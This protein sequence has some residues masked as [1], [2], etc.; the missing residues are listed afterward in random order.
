[1][2]LEE[3]EEQEGLFRKVVAFSLVEVA[4]V[5]LRHGIGRWTGPVGTSGNT[6]NPGGGFGAGCGEMT[7]EVG[8]MNGCTVDSVQRIGMG[9]S[10][11]YYESYASFDF[12]KY[13][14]ATE[15]EINLRNRMKSLWNY[16]RGDYKGPGYGGMSGGIAGGGT[17]SFRGINGD[18]YFYIPDCSQAGK[19]GII[20]YNNSCKI[21]A[22]N[23]SYITTEDSNNMSKEERIESQALIYA[24]VGFNVK[25]I[26]ELLE[27]KK[28][29]SRT[30]EDLVK[31]WS[32][33]DNTENR[34]IDYLALTN[35]LNYENGT[36]LGLGIGSGAGGFQE[37]DG[38]GEFNQIN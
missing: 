10:G 27:V 38:N 32:E 36:G 15:E 37:V 12:E 28:V 8:G 29:I 22:Y 30:A 6:F 1:M 4:Q 21:Y 2:L 31:E 26:R 16:I 17:E 19:G 7:F 25:K 5:F 11:S 18:D 14:C 35:Y 3:Q 20:N 9:V 34:D 24:Q 33:Y 23:G 13:N